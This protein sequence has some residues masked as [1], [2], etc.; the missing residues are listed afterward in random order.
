MTNNSHIS[1]YNN[2]MSFCFQRMF[3]MEYI[4]C[5]SMSILD[6]ISEPEINIPHLS[7]ALRFKYIPSEVFNGKAKLIH[8]VMTILIPFDNDECVPKY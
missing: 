4:I 1:L 5:I 8:Y 2:H 7:T 3:I 6:Y